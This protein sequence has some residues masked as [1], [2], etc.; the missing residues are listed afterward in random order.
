MSLLRVMEVSFNQHFV[1]GLLSVYVPPDLFH[2]I[3]DCQGVKGKRDH[4]ER[5]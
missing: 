5:N 3:P 2:H 1:L 4:K